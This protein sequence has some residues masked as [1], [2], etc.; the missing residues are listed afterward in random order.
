MRPIVLLI[1]LC[2]HC[3]L[4]FAERC[5]SKPSCFVKGLFDFNFPKEGVYPIELTDT[6]DNYWLKAYGDFNSDLA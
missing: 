3:S 1:I 4:V 2:L 6:V 5:T